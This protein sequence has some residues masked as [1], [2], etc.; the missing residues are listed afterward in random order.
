[1]TWIRH[2]HGALNLDHVA[3]V[4]KHHN[5]LVVLELASGKTVRLL[6]EHAQAALDAAVREI[7]PKP[8]RRRPRKKA[9]RIQEADDD[10]TRPVI[11]DAL[12][13]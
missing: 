7:A 1:M 9:E 10:D 13:V 11:E 12:G 2:E 6:G 8:P 4:T 5:D 3:M